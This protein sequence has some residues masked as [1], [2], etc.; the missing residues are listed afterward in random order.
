MTSELDDPIRGRAEPWRDD[1]KRCVKLW[2]GW[3]C[4]W[5]GI[6]SRTPRGRR[7]D[8]AEP[9]AL[10]VGPAYDQ[11][12]KLAVMHAGRVKP[13]DTWPARRSSR[14]S[15]ARRSSCTTRPTRSSRPGGPSPPSST[16]W[17]APSSGT[18]SRSSWS[19]ISRLQQVILADSIRTRLKEI[20]AKATTPAEDKERL[21]KLAAEV[22]RSPPRPSAPRQEQ[23][24]PGRRRRRGRPSW[25]R[26]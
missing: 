10:G 24:A 26:S 6:S 9:K 14:S 5:P 23:Q 20:A 12:G 22:P 15:P 7:R 4:S 18:T 3:P 16:G 21:T 8:E 17:S 13:L 2:P 25:P 11:I 19:T 1:M